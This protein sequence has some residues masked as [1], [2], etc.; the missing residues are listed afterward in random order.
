MVWMDAPGQLT[1]RPPLQMSQVQE[2]VVLAVMFTPLAFG[3]ILLCVGLLAHV[4]LGP[5]RLAT[6]DTEW[7]VTEPRWTKGR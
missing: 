4:V 6:W 3:V 7:Q 1:G 2:Q 5:R